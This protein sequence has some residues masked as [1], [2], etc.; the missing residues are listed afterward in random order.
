MYFEDFS[1]VITTV[2]LSRVLRSLDIISNE[3][4]SESTD[5][6]SVCVLLDHYVLEDLCELCDNRETVLSSAKELA[7]SWGMSCEF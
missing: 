2:L 1:S 3:M 5:I 6:T 7:Q 4:Q